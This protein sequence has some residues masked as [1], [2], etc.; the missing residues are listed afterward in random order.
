MR[1][2]QLQLLADGE[3]NDRSSQ[4]PQD[5]K[6]PAKLDPDGDQEC[7]KHL[8]KCQPL[9]AKQWQHLLAESG[10]IRW[11][12]K[13]G[14]YSDK[15]VRGLHR[16]CVGR[17]EGSKVQCV[18]KLAA[19]RHPVTLQHVGEAR[20]VGSATPLGLD[21]MK[22]SRRTRRRSPAGRRRVEQRTVASASIKSSSQR[23]EE[24]AQL[25]R[26]VCPRLTPAAPGERLSGAERVAAVHARVLAR[27]RRTAAD[28]EGQ[29]L[30]SD[31]NILVQ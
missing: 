11:C 15:I 9:L 1:R 13:C 4:G 8:G 26:A 25:P 24:E 30:R 17:A 21:K 7:S 6:Q 12:V 20:W 19:G 22:R 29:C 23:G 28:T 18:E 16:K 14:C 31:G 2:A 27:V 5:T 10:G 3:Q